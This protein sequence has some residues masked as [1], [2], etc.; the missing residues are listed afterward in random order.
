MEYFLCFWSFLLLLRQTQNENNARCPRWFTFVTVVDQTNEYLGHRSESEHSGEWMSMW[1][2]WI[3]TFY[4]FP[5]YN[6]AWMRWENENRDHFVLSQVAKQ[7][8]IKGNEK[9][10]YIL[11]TIHII[12]KYRQTLKLSLAN[13]NI[14]RSFFLSY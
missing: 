4:V 12:Q 2:Y 13:S 14:F 10:Q 7:E 1:M 3:T 6:I 8:K 9:K 5:R 11:E